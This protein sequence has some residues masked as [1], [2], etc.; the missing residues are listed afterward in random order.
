[1]VNGSIAVKVRNST[2]AL[3]FPGNQA[4]ALQFGKEVDATG[5]ALLPY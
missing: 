4:A 5:Y 2:A 3:P 1:M